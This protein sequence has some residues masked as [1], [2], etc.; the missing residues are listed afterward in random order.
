[1][2]AKEAALAALQDE[3]FYRETLELTEKGKRF[4]YSEIEALGL[5]Y[6]PSHTNFVLI[7]TRL[8][9]Q[10]VTSRLI[11]RGV[12]VR[13]AGSYD[14]AGY[15]RVTVGSAEQ[16][17]RFVEALTRTLADARPNEFKIT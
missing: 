4:L 7:D 11:E 15:I 10:W 12:I 5:S 17:E 8:D 6:I 2:L 3:S 9:D 14:M 16:N 1:V 13:P